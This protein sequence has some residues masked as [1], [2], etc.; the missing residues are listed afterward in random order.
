MALRWLIEDVVVDG[1]VFVPGKSLLMEATGLDP[2]PR[3]FEV[4]QVYESAMRQLAK[5]FGIRERRSVNVF[6]VVPGEGI[7]VVS[8]RMW[9]LPAV[10]GAHKCAAYMFT[11]DASRSGT[12]YSSLLGKA[13]VNVG[14][15]LRAGV[16]DPLRIAELAAEGRASVAIALHLAIDPEVNITLLTGQELVEHMLATLTR[17]VAEDDD[18]SVAAR[19]EVVRDEL[20]LTLRAAY[21]PPD[22]WHGELSASTASADADETVTVTVDSDGSTEGIGYFAVDFTDSANP[23]VGETSDVWAVRIDESGV[24]TVIV[25]LDELDLPQLAV[26]A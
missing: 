7:A 6:P 12:V 17:D 19:V 16:H 2:V 1:G 10:R 3:E 21:T 26:Y 8:D 24:A 4:F 22:D 13:T 9:A 5:H 11:A 18:A 20:T 23:D 15:A 25:D 14:G